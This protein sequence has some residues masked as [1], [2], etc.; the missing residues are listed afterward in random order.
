MSELEKLK[1]PILNDDYF[2]F[3]NLIFNKVVYRITNFK[4]TKSYQN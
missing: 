4:F 1:L 3:E 2:K